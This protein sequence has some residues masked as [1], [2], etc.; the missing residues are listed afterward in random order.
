MVRIKMFKLENYKTLKH[1][2]HVTS[3]GRVRVRFWVTDTGRMP[4]GRKHAR[5]MCCGWKNISR[6]HILVYIIA[7]R[8]SLKIGSEKL[9]KNI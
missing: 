6:M 2:N 7:F 4:K 5:P 9:K 1:E 3:S 8:F